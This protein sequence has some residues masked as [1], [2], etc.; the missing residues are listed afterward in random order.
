MVRPA[1]GRSRVDRDVMNR[2]QRQTIHGGLLMLG[3]MTVLSL[4][5]MSVAVYVDSTVLILLFGGLTAFLL[6]EGL[7]IGSVMVKT[8]IRQ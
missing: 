2:V 4:I 5:P 8:V 1:R 7:I 6:V 3:F